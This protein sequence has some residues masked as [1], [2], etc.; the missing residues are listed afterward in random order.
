[1][2]DTYVYMYTY[3]CIYTY[4]YIIYIYIIYK[5]ISDKPDENGTRTSNVISVSSRKCSI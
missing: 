2:T 4:I 1:M 3:R 5:Y